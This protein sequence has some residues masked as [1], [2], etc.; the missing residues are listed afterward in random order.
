MRN[1]RSRWL[2]GVN[3]ALAALT[4]AAIAWCFHLA[5]QA[6]E[7]T[8]RRYGHNVDSGAYVALFAIIFLVPP[9]IL[10]TLA[11]LAF[12]RSW[13]VRWYIDGAVV[14]WLAYCVIGNYR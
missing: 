9:A 2:A 8:V 11:G 12:W 13:R 5:R 6:A 1:A 7:D 10:F 4:V 14:L 3:W